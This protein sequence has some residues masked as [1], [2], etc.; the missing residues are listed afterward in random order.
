MVRAMDRWVRAAA[1]LALVISVQACGKDKRTDT[2]PAASAQALLAAAQTG[3]A[4]T[5]EAHL[6]RPAIR[7]DLR[8]QLQAVARANGLDVAGGA[9]D[10]ALDRMITPEAFHLVR[11]QDGAQLTAPPTPAQVA[12]LM[13]P[14]A[15]DRACLHDL[16]APQRCL[17]TFARDA[18]GWR[19][20]A[21]PATDLTIA[22]PPAPVKK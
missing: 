7:A 17:L 18:A 1:L 19:L 5:F 4:R 14:L 2:D 9:A 21:M 8:E 13:R 22:V 10:F 12:T 20:V 11:S 16:T 15:K 3:D 6:D